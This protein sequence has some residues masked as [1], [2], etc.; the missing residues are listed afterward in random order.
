[1]LQVQV[2]THKV[3]LVIHEE[4]KRGFFRKG[5]KSGITKLLT[6]RVVVHKQSSKDDR[7]D[8]GLSANKL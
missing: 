6:L 8:R 7:E 3:Y 2:H 4:K 1:M 5:G